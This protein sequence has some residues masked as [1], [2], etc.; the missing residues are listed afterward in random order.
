MGGPRF[1]LYVKQS[2]SGGIQGSCPFSNKAF[3]VMMLKVPEKD[4]KVISVDLQ[5]KPA[6]FLKMNPSKY[7]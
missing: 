4:F 3:M 2:S 1:D 6:E 5:K 7:Q